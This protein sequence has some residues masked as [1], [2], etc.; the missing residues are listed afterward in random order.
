MILLPVRVEL[1][2]GIHSGSTCSL[3]IPNIAF[4]MRP[5]AGDFVILTNEGD[6][7]FALSIKAVA[8]YTNPSS[9]MVLTKE[10]TCDD[11]DEMLVTL[12]WFK[13]RYEIEDFRAAAAPET[14]YVLY[15]TVIHLMDIQDDV[16][17]VRYD[18]DAVKVLAETCRTIWIANQC[19]VSGESNGRPPTRVEITDRLS[20]T[21]PDIETFHRLVF[22][23]RQQYPSG[24]E[25]RQVL[26]EWNISVNEN[27]E[28]DWDVDDD[29][30][31]FVGGIIFGRL[32][33]ETPCFLRVE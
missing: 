28:Y 11:Y 3:T 6:D 19:R 20:D 12:D 24:V 25:L 21:N 13:A 14:Y 30:C 23:Y 15:R 29:L 33:C 2:V 26:K 4:S 31:R 27:N 9:A 18:S 17:L 22:G 1:Q 16:P 5:V 8:H 7:P 10:I 32:K